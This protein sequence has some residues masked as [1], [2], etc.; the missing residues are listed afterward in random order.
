MNGNIIDLSRRVAL[1]TG[2][3][4][5]IGRAISQRLAACGASVAVCD[6][7]LADAERTAAD[8]GADAKAFALDVSDEV[9]CKAC[10]A[11]V[12]R[13][14]GLANILVNN[15]GITQ[16][17]VGTL[18]QRSEDWD[19]VID[20]NLKG[21]FLMSQI[22]AQGLVAAGR[23]GAI[24]NLASIAG[25]MAHRA[26]NS[27]GVSKAGVIMLTKTMGA[28]LANRRIRVN[29][30]A[31]GYINTQLSKDAVEAGKASRDAF[32]RRIPMGDFGEPD[33]IA[34]VAAFL[35]SDWSSYMTGAV[36]PV[37]GGWCAF[38]GPGVDN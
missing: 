23:P 10:V 37:D 30:I 24:V 12:E 26:S 32:T 7:S 19:R 4:N 15:A 22:V 35:A 34:R 20:V 11:S 5:G 13:E 36:V 28:D 14:M 21:V 38:G 18:K 31:P 33:D 2:G 25:I 8:I 6:L 1:V 29:A 3:A 17:I 9:S 16:A 27:Y